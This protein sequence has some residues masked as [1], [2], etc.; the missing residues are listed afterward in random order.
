MMNNQPSS[1]WDM[2][3]KQRL[4]ME[5]SRRDDFYYNQLYKD[6]DKGL[7][8][9][10]A[11]TAYGRQWNDWG[12]GI[13]KDWQRL[14]PSGRG[15]ASIGG[16]AVAGALVGAAIGSYVPII[17]TALGAVVGAAVGGYAGWTA[18]GSPFKF[19]GPSKEAIEAIGIAATAPRTRMVNTRA[20]QTMRQA[21]MAAMHNSVYA[22]R[23]ALGNEASLAHM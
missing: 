14:R 17:G 7:F 5:K 19:V 12:T 16:G 2:P 8:S 23:G 11:W 18:G 3:A 15:I 21:T 6:R 20:A 1:Y 4:E 13:G 22:L 10:K 9:A